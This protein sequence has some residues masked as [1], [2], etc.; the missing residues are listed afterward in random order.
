MSCHMGVSLKSS[1]HYKSSNSLVGS[2]ND[3]PFI[4]CESSMLPTMC[5]MHHETF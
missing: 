3:E 1:L 4:G 5:S 2:Q